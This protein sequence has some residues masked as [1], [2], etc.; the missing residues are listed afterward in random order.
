MVLYA[1][2]KTDHIWDDYESIVKIQWSIK[3]RAAGREHAEEQI[4]G[5]VESL[6]SEVRYQDIADESI[7]IEVYK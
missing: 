6:L 4:K 2:A 5:I 1:E 3:V 7:E